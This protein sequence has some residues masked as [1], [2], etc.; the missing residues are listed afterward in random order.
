M[1]A[2]VNIPDRIASLLRCPR[3]HGRLDVRAAVVACTGCGME[4]PIVDGAPVLIDR[5]R[6]KVAVAGAKDAIF[7]AW[8]L[9]G[10]VLSTRV[11][12]AHPA[13]RIGTDQV[14]QVRWEGGRVVLQPPPRL[15]NG[16]MN[17]L[18]LEWERVG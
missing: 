10:A 11:D 3:C 12:A 4:Y 1:A 16:V 2:G 5:A 8:S 6:R 14:R 15:V 9:D 18:E 7:P 17:H 13:N